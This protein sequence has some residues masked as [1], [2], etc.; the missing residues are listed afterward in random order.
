MYITKILI[1]LLQQVRAAPPTTSSVAQQSPAT[2][3]NGPAANWAVAI[4][5]VILAFVAVFQ[6]WIKS[7]IFK[8]VLEIE[9]RAERPFAEKTH[10]N[11]DRDVYYFRLGIRN[12]GRIVAKDVQVYAHKVRRKKSDSKC[13]DVSRFTPMALRWTH[14]PNGT[15]PRLLP[16]MPPVFCDLGHIS[17]PRN[18]CTFEGLEEVPAGKTVFALET[19]VIPNSRANLLGPGEYRVCL[20]VAASNCKPQSF[21]VR[22]KMRDGQWFDDEDRMYRDGVGLTCEEG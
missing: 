11:P 9:T 1:L 15:L 16:D 12:T 7:L 10:F 8:P 21:T 6:E 5:T 18:I 2:F 19:E 22:I 3:W 17:D 4:G 14:R 20:K 13:E